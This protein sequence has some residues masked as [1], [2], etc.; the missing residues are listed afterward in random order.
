[1]EDWTPPACPPHITD[2]DTRAKV[3]QMVPCDHHVTLR[4]MSEHLGISLERV[5]HIVVQVLGYRKVSAVQVP[6]C[7]NDER[8]ALNGYFLGTSAVL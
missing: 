2:T 6:K 3:D 8:K 7:L 4:H 5:H 1:M